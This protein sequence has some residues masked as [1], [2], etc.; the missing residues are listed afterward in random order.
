M[1]TRETTVTEGYLASIPADVRRRLD[2]EPGDKLV[3][4]V[5]EGDLEV[6]VRRR[7]EGAFG[8]FAPFDFGEETHAA[9]DHDEV[10]P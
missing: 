5:R 4:E 3:W 2:I 6:R 8:D 7:R 10:R 9:R 1:A